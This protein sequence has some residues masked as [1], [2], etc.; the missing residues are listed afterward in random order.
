M[1]KKLTAILAVACMGTALIPQTAYADEYVRG[2]ANSDGVFTLSDIV[3][4]QKYILGG[5]IEISC[6]QNVDLCKDNVIDV[7]DLCVLKNEFLYDY[8]PNYEA[9]KGFTVNSITNKIAGARKY[10]S[11]ELYDKK[12]WTYAE[13]TEYFGIDLGNLGS[14][15]FVND[16]YTAVLGDEYPVTVSKDGK[17]AEDMT[18]ITYANAEGKSLKIMAGKVSAPYDCIYELDNKNMTTIC[19][20]EVLFGG[21]KNAD[22]SAYDFLYADFK[23]DDIIYRFE[24]KG[25]WD[26]EFFDIVTRF[27]S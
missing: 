12:M 6:M 15:L 23:K 8:N 13:L 1:K 19:G 9:P 10:F 2:D 18:Y 26:K 22:E 27:V 3:I 14:D 21:I 20:V 24:A 17:V 4:V 11:P 7:F 25:M 16:D 5:K